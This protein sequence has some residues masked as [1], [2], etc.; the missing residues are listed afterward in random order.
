MERVLAQETG[1]RGKPV[2]EI[3]AEYTRQ[4]SLGQWVYPPEVADMAV[5]L[6]SPKA[7]NI[8]D[9]FIGVDGNTE[10]LGM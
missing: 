4:I 1:G 6:A 9:Q 8:S 10:T 5:F 7:R 2:E 3:K